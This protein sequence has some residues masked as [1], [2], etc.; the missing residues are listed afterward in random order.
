[1]CMTVIEFVQNV[2]RIICQS[3]LDVRVEEGNN[4]TKEVIREGNFFLLLSSVRFLS[5]LSYVREERES[6]KQNLSHL[7][8]LER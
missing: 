6:E 5:C 1:M 4:F 2:N 7:D 3:S 8:Y